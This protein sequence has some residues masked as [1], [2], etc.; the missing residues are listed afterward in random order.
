MWKH[1]RIVK[2][3]IYCIINGEPHGLF[4]WPPYWFQ[5]V[6]FGSVAFMHLCGRLRS[7]TP[8]SHASNLDFVGWASCSNVTGRAATKTEISKFPQRLVTTGGLMWTTICQTTC[9][10]PYHDLGAEH[11]VLQA[12]WWL[13]LPH[14]ICSVENFVQPWRHLKKR[15]L[16]I[17]FWV[18]LLI[19]K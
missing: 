12:V 18:L 1:V 6:L 5:D 3:V 11:L 8:L 19:I 2:S 10:G 4:F 7:A 15:L 14:A 17:Y 16:L 9:Y 13:C